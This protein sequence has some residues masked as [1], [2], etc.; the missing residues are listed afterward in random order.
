MNSTA[1]D[2]MADALAQA[3]V[4]RIYGVVG[5]PST[6]SRIPYGD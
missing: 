5:I 1:A 3:G 2:Y 6:A 4:K